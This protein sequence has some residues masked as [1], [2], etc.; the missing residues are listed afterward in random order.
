M[1][2]V[3]T[4][5]EYLESGIVTTASPMYGGTAMPS[6][7]VF[8][9]GQGSAQAHRQHKQRM[10]ALDMNGLLGERSATELPE[11]S[12]DASSI[13]EVSNEAEA[14]GRAEEDAAQP[15]AF[16]LLG[17]LMRKRPTGTQARR[18]QALATEAEERARQEAAESESGQDGTT[19]HHV[20][21]SPEEEVQPMLSQPPV[22][23]L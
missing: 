22:D 8:G 11:V 9:T 17:S 6:V 16:Q 15:D 21:R 19:V 13:S 12:S 1:P 18:A 23:L 5:E 14:T 7:S 2:T 3:I 20:V 4:R 10:A